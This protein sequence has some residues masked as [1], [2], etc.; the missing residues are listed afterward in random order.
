[1]LRFGH[2]ARRGYHLVVPANARDLPSV[3]IERVQTRKGEA[4]LHVSSAL[5]T[6]KGELT[7]DRMYIAITCSTKELNSLNSRL[8]EA[9]VAVYK[10][11]NSVIQQLLDRV[12]PY[13][14][15]LYAMVESVALLDMLLRYCSHLHNQSLC[16]HVSLGSSDTTLS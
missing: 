12:R 7:P 9:L 16:T 10:L 5:S 15:S 8:K 6:Q 13:A 1:M 11:S 2:R 4:H 14:S 3:I